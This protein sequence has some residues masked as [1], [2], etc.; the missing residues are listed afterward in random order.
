M[1]SVVEG[2]SVMGVTMNNLMNAVSRL[3]L[4]TKRSYVVDGAYGGW[5]LNVLDGNGEA[6][7]TYGR[8]SKPDLYYQVLAMIRFI[9]A[10]KVKSR[11][12]NDFWCTCG[13]LDKRMDDIEYFENNECLCGVSHHHYHDKKCGKVYQVG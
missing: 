1:V 8:V 11:I 12:Q 4:L 10:E 7:I 13:D 5:K 9:E 3:N 2:D 6:E